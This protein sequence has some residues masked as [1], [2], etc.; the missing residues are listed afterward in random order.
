MKNIIKTI[1]LMFLPFIGWAQDSVI[2]ISTKNYDLP[3]DGSNIGNKEGWVFHKGNNTNWAKETI[4]LS[5]WEKL[6]PA[7]LSYKYADKNGRV[8]GWFRIKIRIDSSLGNREFGFRL[9]SFAATDLYINGQ[10]LTTAGNTGNNGRLFKSN[11]PKEK[12]TNPYHLKSGET[13]TIAIHVVDYTTRIS[14]YLLKSEIYNSLDYIISITG[15]QFVNLYLEYV[16]QGFAIITISVSI[17]AILSLFFWILFFQNSSEKNLRVI[18][19][20][21]TSIAITF[22]SSYQLRGIQNPNY[23]ELWATMNSF[24]GALSFLLMLLLIVNI[25]KRKVTKALKVFSVVYF[26]F[27]FGCYL[28]PANI[29][30]TVNLIL[31]AL[32]FIVFIYYVVT[33]WKNLK[34]AQWAVV[35]GLLVFLLLLILLYVFRDRLLSLSLAIS[36]PLSLL[37]YVSMRFKEIITEV[38][39]NANQVLQLSEEKKEQAEK[40][41]EILQEEVNKQTSEIRTTLENLKSTQSQLIQSEKMASLGELTAGIAHEIQNPLNFVNNFSEVSIELIEEVKSEKLKAKSERDEQLETALLDDIAQNLKKIA[42]HGKRADGIV[43]GML[44]HSR[45]SNTASKEPTNINKLAD[46]YLRLAYHGL[47]AKDKTFNATM[48]TDF[49]ETIGNINI[50]P[51]DIGRVILNLITNAFYAVDEK[52]KQIVKDYEPTVS[53]STKKVGDKVLIFV[54]DNGNGIPEQ[55]LDKIFQPFYTTKPTGQ[56]TG[57]GLSMSYDI[58]KAHGGELKVE[59]K[60]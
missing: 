37:V 52:K 32:L 39:Q 49:D 60:E 3:S 17:C 14:P 12:I 9:A 8:E 18:A 21:T 6:K 46:E 2:N 26:I 44:Q 4:D 11:D 7:D 40:Q 58:V 1:L 16:Q 13:Y 15:P 53:I 22:Y 31:T 28:V 48:E 38:Q 34:G 42:H 54:K 19:F 45:S 23:V 36:F 29:S 47:R 27:L 30:D 20:C 57:L 56:G 50:I 59:T 33:S 35:A 10:F 55:V 24:F 25:F 41:Q 43:K 5:S 51:Q